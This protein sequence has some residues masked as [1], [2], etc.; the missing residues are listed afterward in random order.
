MCAEIRSLLD[1]FG[2]VYN[3]DFFFSVY[4][5]FGVYDRFDLKGY[6]TGFGNRDW[7]RAH[8]CSGKTAVAVT[9]LLKNGATCAGKTVM[10]EFAFG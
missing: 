9:A 3:I 8:E 7:E 4:F 6:V 2:V 5:F 10:D 1:R